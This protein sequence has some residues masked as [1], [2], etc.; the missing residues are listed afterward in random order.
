[1]SSSES[2]YDVAV[3]PAKLDVIHDFDGLRA[4]IGKFAVEDYGCALD[5]TAIES[6]IPNTIF[7]PDF[8]EARVSTLF[9]LKTL[10]ARGYPHLRW[11]D[12]GV[13][14]HSRHPNTDKGF[15]HDYEVYDDDHEAMGPNDL[16]VG[17]HESTPKFGRLETPDLEITFASPTDK[18]D[19]TFHSLHLAQLLNAGMTDSSL[20]VPSSF[21]SVRLPE[22][23]TVAFTFK[24]P[25]ARSQAHRFKS[26]SSG[27]GQSRSWALFGHDKTGRFK[28]G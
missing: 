20:L 12:L 26:L 15:H 7:N 8:P 14:R 22:G 21:R 11:T 1:M 27:V 16:A 13:A 25:N 28:N 24:R 6:T 10:L 23:G 4:V 19:D 3:I 2:R 17:Y 9:A 18:Y 5:T